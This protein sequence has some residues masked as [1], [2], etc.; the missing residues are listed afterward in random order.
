MT[1]SRYVTQV[2]SAAMIR[3]LWVAPI[4]QYRCLWN[5]QVR[6]GNLTLSWLEILN[7]VSNVRLE[8]PRFD[9]NGQVLRFTEKN[10]AS[11]Q[12]PIPSRHEDLPS[13]ATQSN[14]RQLPDTV[15][16]C[17]AAPRHHQHGKRHKIDHRNSNVTEED[18]DMQVEKPIV[19]STNRQLDFPKFTKLSD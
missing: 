14:R 2:C 9:A 7:C 16:D 3:T 10:K 15:D 4:G 5:M 17:L 19:S 13:K 6:C 1:G 12:T 18:V 11:A 8:K